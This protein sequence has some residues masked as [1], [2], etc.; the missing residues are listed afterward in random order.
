MRKK[1][2][3]Y[4]VEDDCVLAK[5]ITWNLQE[6]SSCLVKSFVSGE[7]MIVQMNNESPDIVLLDYFLP[8]MNGREVYDV[9]KSELPETT[10]IGI[11]GQLQL[12]EVKE[13]FNCGLDA[14]IEKDTDF[15]KQIRNEV[16]KTIVDSQEEEIVVEFEDSLDKKIVFSG[17]LGLMIILAV[18]YYSFLE[19]L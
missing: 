8:G 18:I 19:V 17:V 1:T 10:V 16:E 7:E 14:A 3:V 6:K 13:F 15:I 4:L 9:I 2:L 5:I 11:S 12:K